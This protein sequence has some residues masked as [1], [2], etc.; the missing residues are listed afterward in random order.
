MSHAPTPR[1]AEVRRRTNETDVEVRLALD[2]TGQ[3]Q[4]ATGLPFLDHMLANLALH[5]GFDLTLR[6]N[7]DLE[8]DDHH[9]VE[10]TALAL[11]EAFDRALGERRG[12]ARFG[13]AHVPLDEALT[14]AVVDLS[15]RPFAAVALAFGRERL[16]TCA[17][18]NLSHFFRSF[19]TA[20]RLTLHLRVLEGEND[21]HKAESAFK[22]IAVALRA[23]VCRTSSAGPGVAI[24]SSKGVL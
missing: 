5:A 13:A 4:I 3:R 7:G 12:I 10:D 2:G 17:T 11:G 21:H 8:V 15:G 23:A 14:R 20:A 22:A 18:E 16:G 6:A 19:A 24:P 9:T 1:T